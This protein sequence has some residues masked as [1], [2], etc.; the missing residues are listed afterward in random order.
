MRKRKSKRKKLT[1]SERHLNA[2]AD[3]GKRGGGHHDA[4]AYL[5]TEEEIAAQCAA[6]RAAHIAEKRATDPSKYIA[7]AGG[8]PTVFA[9]PVRFGRSAAYII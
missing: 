4:G 3:S 6:F 1:N 2:R 5:P 7:N 9:R 8:N